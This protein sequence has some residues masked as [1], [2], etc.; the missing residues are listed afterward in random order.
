[1]RAEV[2][3]RRAGEARAGDRHRRAACHGPA[4]GLMPVTAM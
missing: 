4:V 3:R 1:M 2:H